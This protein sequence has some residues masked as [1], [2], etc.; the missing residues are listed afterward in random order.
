[1]NTAI[2]SDTWTGLSPYD[3]LTEYERTEDMQFGASLK[4]LLGG[5]GASLFLFGCGVL[6]ITLELQGHKFSGR[7]AAVLNWP[8]LK[9]AMG[10]LMVGLGLVI[11]PGWWQ[12]WLM[13]YSVVPLIVTDRELRFGTP[14]QTIRLN[15]IT[16]ITFH[17]LPET[18]S[19][20]ARVLSSRVG[21]SRAIGAAPLGP[22]RLS[23]QSRAEPIKLDLTVLKGDPSRIGLIICGRIQKLQSRTGNANV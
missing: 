16:K 15:T 4:L 2:D 7:N 23:T 6:L 20:L 8:T 11:I 12:R 14:S 17:G 18:L 5:V 19:E 3:V 22:L 21:G 13:R 9:A 10:C 1:M